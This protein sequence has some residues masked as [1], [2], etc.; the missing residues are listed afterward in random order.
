MTIN[1]HSFVGLYDRVL[2][3]ADHLLTKGSG[4]AAEQGV[5]EADM[6]G[7]K[8]ADDMLPLSFQFAIIVNF[9]KSFTARTAGI[10]VPEAIVHAD[11]DVAG[12]HAAIAEARAFLA[13]I[14]EDQIVGR[15]DVPLTVKLGDVMEPT[16][17]AAQWMTGFALTNVQF[18]MGMAYAI[19][20]MKGVPLG[21]ID[22][23]SN[24]L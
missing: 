8:L 22:L 7:W 19:M 24:G 1:L 6:L 9:S 16:L 5:S 14:S 3:T 11:I 18:H 2:A 4:F 13:G 15:E 12:F 23:F 17:P 21:K 10:E 20:R